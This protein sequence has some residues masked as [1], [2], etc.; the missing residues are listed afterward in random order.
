MK[1]HAKHTPIKRKKTITAEAGG[2]TDVAQK[3]V[4]ATSTGRRSRPWT[5]LDPLAKR[6]LLNAKGPKSE[7]SG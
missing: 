1:P 2:I 4:A 7:A 5:I 6:V 3:E